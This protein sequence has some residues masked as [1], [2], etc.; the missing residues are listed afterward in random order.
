MKPE[1]PS[2]TS[3][4]AGGSLSGPKAR[5]ADALAA[6]LSKA[7]AARQAGVDRA[8]L[9]RWSRE[10]AFQEA[11]DAA[12][13]DL[14]EQA[15]KGLSD[16]VP[17]ALQVIEDALTGKKVTAQMA[18]VALDTVKAAA[19]ISGAKEGEGTFLA[20]IRELESAGSGF[21]SD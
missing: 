10:P 15:T 8:T 4:T 11:V 9:T 21:G 5:A 7:E 20:K 16:L 19:N 12:R 6:G 14:A 1:S 18:R 2:S 17:Q 3:A 13:P